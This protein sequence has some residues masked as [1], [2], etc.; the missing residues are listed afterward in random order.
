MVDLRSADALARVLEETGAGIAMIGD[1]LQAAPV[2]HVGAMA[3]LTRSADNVV[4]LR[5]V[6][7]FTDPQYGELTLRLRNVSSAVAATEVAAE[8][9][10]G[11]HMRRVSSTDAAHDAMVDAWFARVR[12]GERVALVV[13]TNDDAD[14]ISEAIQQRR[15]DAGELTADAVALG[16]GGQRML[17]GDVIQTRRNDRAADVQNRATWIITGIHDDRLSLANLADSTEQRTIRAEYAADHAHLAYASTVHGIQGETVDASIVGPGVDAAGLYVGLT[18][19]K[20]WNEAIVVAGSADAARAELADAM[21]RGVPEPTI[22][23][24]RRAAQID[25]NRAARRMMTP[26]ATGPVARPTVSRGGLWI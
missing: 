18:R 23:D 5:A 22:E 25:L 13:A 16:R 10:T 9:D 20:L 21:R 11:G 17:V 14:A 12:C 8:L 7:R 26:D 3:L 2:G 15:L 4:E 24:S 6:H 1:P 19:G